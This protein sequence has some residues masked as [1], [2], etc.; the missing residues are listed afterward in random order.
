M[1]TTNLVID[2]NVITGFLDSKD[3]WH[4]KS[5]AILT[6]CYSADPQF[7]GIFL[8][9]LLAESLSTIQTQVYRLL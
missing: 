6:L 4:D 8:D 2:S 7:K 1:L 9:F 5:K 3:K